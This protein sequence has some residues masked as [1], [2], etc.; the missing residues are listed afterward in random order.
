[1]VYNSRAIA[2]GVALIVSLIALWFLVQPEPSYACMCATP[3][4]LEAINNSAGIFMG[5][6]ISARDYVRIRRTGTFLGSTSVIEFDVEVVWKGARYQ[7]MSLTSVTAGGSSCGSTFKEGIKYVVYSE[8]GSHIGM[9]SRTRELSKAGYDL[10][11]L[12]R[13]YMPDYGTMSPTPD[14]SKYEIRPTASPDVKTAQDEE[15]VA[16]QVG[17]TPTPEMSDAPRGGGCGRSPQAAD[18]SVIGL[19]VGF[20]WFGLRKKP[21]DTS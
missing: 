15:V 16:T 21:S 7:T 17:I 13:G 8:D 20:A 2:I 14:V 5:K 10:A 11:L 19:M 9:C 3:E 4:P 12:G 6:V 1:M 18:L